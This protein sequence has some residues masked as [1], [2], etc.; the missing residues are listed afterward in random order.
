MTGSKCRYQGLREKKTLSESKITSQN[1]VLQNIYFVTAN[2]QTLLCNNR[3]DIHTLIDKSDGTAVW[4]GTITPGGVDIAVPIALELATF[5][6]LGLITG[7]GKQWCGKMA[8]FPSV[9]LGGRTHS[10][11]VPVVVSAPAN[12]FWLATFLP[13]QLLVKKQKCK[14]HDQRKHSTV[15][16]N[17]MTNL[18]KWLIILDSC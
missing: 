7:V 14:Q 2:L 9:W 4:V 10:V 1:S 3:W 16:E 17:N 6:A 11:F 12:I 15:E 18:A 5:V 8:P 13:V